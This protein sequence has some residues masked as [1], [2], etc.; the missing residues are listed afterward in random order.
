M[1]NIRTKRARQR[2]QRAADL[3]L[4]LVLAVEDADFAADLRAIWPRLPDWRHVETY[5]GSG[6][7][8][9]LSV[10][11]VQAWLCGETGELLIQM[12][13]EPLSETPLI[14][15]AFKTA[16]N[17]Q[18]VWLYPKGAGPSEE[19]LDAVHAA[20]HAL[21]LRHQEPAPGVH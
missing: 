21:F 16:P 2:A 7:A 14:S 11:L 1:A 20:I 5:V 19:Q 8:G 17:I 3:G 4:I 6:F 18:R 15:L 10:Q 12:T 13:M 9:G